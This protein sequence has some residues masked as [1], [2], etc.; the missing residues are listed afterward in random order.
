M[1]T[2]RHNLPVICLFCTLLKE[3]IKRKM[4]KKYQVEIV[5]ESRTVL[6]PS[7]TVIRFESRC[8]MDVRFCLGCVMCCVLPCLV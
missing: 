2:D 3:H 1:H 6:N 5:A 7:K 8:N 4:L